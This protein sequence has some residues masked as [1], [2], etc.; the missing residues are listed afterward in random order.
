LLR[1]SG[2]I[3]V[4]GDI[5]GNIDDLIRIFEKFGYPPVADY[6]FLGDYVDRGEYSIEVLLLLFALKCKFPNHIY[7][8]RGNHETYQISKV[9]GFL[10]ECSDKFSA[11]MFTQ[12]NYVFQYLPI[13]AILEEKVFCVH[14]GISP[15]LLHVSD[16]DSMEK[17]RLT[18][19]GVFVDLLWSDPSKISFV[20]PFKAPITSYGITFFK[21]YTIT[22]PQFLHN[23]P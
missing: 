15:D 10:K 20:I 11:C 18:L 7:L 12:F 14:G 21:F 16:L 5:H 13:A 6:L 22:S 3:N 8:V 19:S 17:P 9:Y 1:L 23:M 4:V 2:G